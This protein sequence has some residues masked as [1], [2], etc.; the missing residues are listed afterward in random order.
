M[1]VFLTGATGFLGRQVLSRLLADPVVTRVICLVRDPAK[2]PP[3][4]D[5]DRLRVVNGDLLQPETYRQALKEATHV[6]H[7]AALVGL[8]N[9]EAFYTVNREG[10]R[11]LV[12]ACQG[13]A[14][15]QRFLFVSSIS[16]VDRPALGV[17]EALP[18]L[19]ECSP[20]HPGTDYGRSKL[21]AE[22]LLQASGLPWTIAR[23]AYIYGPQPRQGSSMDRLLYDVL[24][25]AHYTRLPWP[26]RVSAMGVDDLADVLVRL[27]THPAAVNRTFF[28]AEPEPV[29]VRQTIESL[30]GLLGVPCRPLTGYAARRM[31]A[32]IRR[33]AFAQP[34]NRMIPVLG[35]DAFV[36]DAAAM[37]A[38]L[39]DTA[40]R[41]LALSMAETVAWYRHAGLLPTGDVTIR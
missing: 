30:A 16:A 40:R 25:Q 8:R 23:P 14:R 3:G 6:L 26:G 39:G 35:T 17:D 29:S 24:R 33:L 21:Q 38:L 28:T 37:T 5:P 32:L 19:N 11:A 15:L 13:A 12:E 4:R 22:A 7:V 41:G 9:G 1:H 36:C 18:P 34:E 20:P 10:T 2:L 27:M 31:K